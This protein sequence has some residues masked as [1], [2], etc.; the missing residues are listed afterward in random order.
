MSDGINMALKKGKHIKGKL[1]MPKP[2]YLIS[3]NN[4]NIFNSQNVEKPNKNNT[5]TKSNKEIKMSVKTINNKSFVLRPK[6]KKVNKEKI[7]K[8]LSKKSIYNKKNGTSFINKNVKKISNNKCHKNNQE[9]KKNNPFHTRIKSFHIDYRDKNFFNAINKTENS[10]IGKTSQKKKISPDNNNKNE[11]KQN[12]NEL[13]Y[14]N[15]EYA[16][17]NNNFNLNQTNNLFDDIDEAS[18]KNTK[19]FEQK[20]MTLDNLSLE[21]KIIILSEKNKKINNYFETEREKTKDIHKNENDNNNKGSAYNKVTHKQKI[22]KLS[23]LTYKDRNVLNSSFNKRNRPFSPN[24]VNK[25][26]NIRKNVLANKEHEKKNISTIIN[27][28]YET[29]SNFSKNRKGIKKENHNSKGPQKKM[30]TLIKQIKDKLQNIQTQRNNNNISTKEHLAKNVSFLK[31]RKTV[32]NGYNPFQLQKLNLK[33]NNNKKAKVIQMSNT[34]RS[35]ITFRK[36]TLLSETSKSKNGK[37]KEKVNHST[38]VQIKDNKNNYKKNKKLHDSSIVKKTNIN[39]SLNLKKPNKII[40]SNEKQ[41]HCLSS[42]SQNDVLTD[43]II[44]NLNKEDLEI[45]DKDK[46]NTEKKS[47]KQKILGPKDLEDKKLEKIEN[48]CQKGF[49]GPGIKKINQDNFFIYNNFM[50]N[51]NYIFTGVCDG[52]GTYG[53]NVSGYLVYNLPLTINDILI[54]EKMETITP[55][56][57]DKVISILKNTFMEIDKNITLDSRIDSYFSGSTCVSIIY[58]PSK[59]ICANLGDSRCIVGKNDGKKWYAQNISNDHK[60]C[61]PLEEERILKKGGRIE[62]YKDDEGHFLGPKRVWLKD[63]D[64]PGLAMSRSFGDRVAHNV[65]VI[66]EPEI[67]EYNFLHEDKFVILASDGIWEFISNDECV[68]YVKDF[69]IKKDIIGALNF[70]YK[71]ASKRWIIEEEVIDDITLIIIFFE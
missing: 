19:L 12:N 24:L 53:H 23:N 48:L 71:E 49:S 2:S 32:T 62:S 40:K 31:E 30:S 41:K 54:R 56:N 3:F 43:F 52:H 42:K 45:K 50:N 58:T 47:I 65:G 39:I 17:T 7:D 10:N 44:K 27:K 5:P 66:S 68:K 61:N 26:N 46:N 14:T 11:N 22:K 29:H 21:E 67:T 59:L 36:S 60:P 25:M 70:L 28:N 51:P 63:E 6:N 18:T 15:N 1:S 9:K 33:K 16:M 4:E 20:T 34:K 64:V 35:P 57:N 37:E 8:I 55:E 69:Y 38:I 13:D